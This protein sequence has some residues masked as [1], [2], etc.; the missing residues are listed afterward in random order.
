MNRIYTLYSSSK[1][2]CTYMSDG[3]TDILIDA[4]K[5][6]KQLCRSLS[7]LGKS[8]DDIRAIFITH[9]HTDH[10]KS[11]DMICKHTDIPIHITST[12]AS[13]G[14]FDGMENVVVHN[15]RYCEDVGSIHIQS[16]PTP[17]DSYG[18]VGYT[19]ALDGVKVG[20]ATDIGH[21][22]GAIFDSLAS[23]SA[24]ILESNHDVDMLK[25]GPYPYNIKQRIL[26]DRGHLSNDMCA[27]TIP[28]LA[29]KGVKSILLAH[30][31][32]ENNTPELA[33]YTARSALEK[34]GIDGVYIGVASSSEPTE[35][36]IGEY[37]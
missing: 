5:S 2:N 28:F 33:L 18:S 21:M 12:C 25:H 22:T 32:E 20:L 15:T 1:G 23:C 11:L 7:S 17:H 34:N 9:E 4:G 14:R 10:I 8:I 19:V 24:L 35:L 29:A 27:E 26:S 37:I 13:S 36:Q 16:F 3:H 31:S 6:Y 30:L